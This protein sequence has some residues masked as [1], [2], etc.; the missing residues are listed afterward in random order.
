MR[1]IAGI[2]VAF[3]F[4]FAVIGLAELLVTRRVITP[5]VGRKTIHISVA[6]WWL[7]AM[8]FHE[9]L[10][11]ALVGP[12]VFIIL[13]YLS[14]RRQLITAMDA[15]ETNGNLGTVYFPISLLVVVIM[16][17][18]FGVPLYVGAI[19]ILVMGYGDGLA[20]LLGM[21]F[22]SPQMTLFRSSKSL[23]GSVTMFVASSLVTLT[24][25]ALTPDF[26]G[27]IILAAVV[28]GIVATGI[29]YATPLGLDNLSVPILTTLFFQG[30]FV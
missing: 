25:V 18:G 13:N 26:S 30:V 27:P 24:V 9:A 19:G 14:Y 16:T 8:A 11:A 3:V 5:P 7:I 4:I 6:H 20:S 23:V 29:E 22:G 21:H 28:T 12:V 2:V 1:E 10:W 15:E 17:Y